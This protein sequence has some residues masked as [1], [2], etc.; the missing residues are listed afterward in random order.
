MLIIGEWSSRDI[1]DS[2][3]S[4]VAMKHVRRLM[5]SP[6]TVNKY[7]LREAT[8]LAEQRIQFTKTIQ[9]NVAT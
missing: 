4:V 8:R 3:V 7:H 5:S 1:R 9:Y 2:S 6:W